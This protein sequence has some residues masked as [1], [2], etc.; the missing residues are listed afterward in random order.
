MMPWRIVHSVDHPVRSTCVS[1]SFH[2]PSIGE[3]LRSRRPDRRRQGVPMSG[4]LTRRAL[5]MD[6]REWSLHY[7]MFPG[8]GVRSTS[9]ASS[10][11]PVDVIRGPDHSRGLP[12][13][14]TSRR[15]RGTPPPTRCARARSQK[16]WHARSRRPSANGLDIGTCRPLRCSPARVRRGSRWTRSPP[17]SSRALAALGFAQPA[18]SPKPVRCGAGWRSSCS[19]SRRTIDRPCHCID[20]CVG[21]G[22]LGPGPPPCGGRERRRHRSSLDVAD[23]RRPT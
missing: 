6:V 21:P 14:S 13:T 11:D 10:P 8:T 23:P 1:N 12:A 2:V 3:R 16:R 18:A 19:T 17:R 22:E 4:S 20:Q 9:R 15:I 7:R 5:N